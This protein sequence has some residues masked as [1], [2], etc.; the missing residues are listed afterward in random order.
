MRLTLVEHVMRGEHDDHQH[1]FRIECTGLPCTTVEWDSPD[2]S[3]WSG[4]NGSIMNNYLKPGVCSNYVDWG[5]VVESGPEGARLPREVAITCRN[6]NRRGSMEE[7]T[8]TV[9]ER[10]TNFFSFTLP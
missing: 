10:K 2:T 7:L 8:G 9:F 4:E 3:Q 5:A 6:R 1:H